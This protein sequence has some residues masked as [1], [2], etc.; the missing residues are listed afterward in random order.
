M[1]PTTSVRSC[2]DESSGTFLAIG[3]HEMNVYAQQHRMLVIA[4]ATAVLIAGNTLVSTPVSAAL[5]RDVAT[6]KLDVGHPP[7]IERNEWERVRIASQHAGAG[8]KQSSRSVADSTES[9]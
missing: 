4:I 9:A 3:W 1:K 7:L 5:K 2:K 8:S 6:Q